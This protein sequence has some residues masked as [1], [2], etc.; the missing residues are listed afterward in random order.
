MF[1]FLSDFI[2]GSMH[3]KQFNSHD[4]LFKYL[5]TVISKNGELKSFSVKFV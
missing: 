4:I 5:D 1:L 2:M 3:L